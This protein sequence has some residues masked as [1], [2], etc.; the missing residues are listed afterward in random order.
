MLSL[1]TLLVV[2][3]PHAVVCQLDGA[4]WNALV[5]AA[6]VSTTAV[7]GRRLGLSLASDAAGGNPKLDVSVDWSSLEGKT[8]ATV[9]AQNAKLGDAL[10]AFW[11]PGDAKKFY[12]E[13]G[14]VTV[15]GLD[16]AGKSVTLVL[17]LVLREGNA[18]RAAKN[19]GNPSHTVKCTLTRVPLV[20]Q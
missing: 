4:N 10:Q 8:A 16:I 9:S 19:S 20:V 1:V 13:K 11:L 7:T 5:D 12:L 2:S 18:L 3:A 14:T 17:D 15:E 6:V